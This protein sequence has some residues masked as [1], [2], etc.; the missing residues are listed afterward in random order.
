MQDL[1]FQAHRITE[2]VET[3]DRSRQDLIKERR[4]IMHIRDDILSAIAS[5]RDVIDSARI[6]HSKPSCHGVSLAVMLRGC[7][8]SYLVSKG[9]PARHDLLIGTSASSSESMRSTVV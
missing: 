5:G 1:P 3:I 8:S 4:T 6:L 7:K 9:W 2:P